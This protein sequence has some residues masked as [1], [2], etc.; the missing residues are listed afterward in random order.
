MERRS[1]AW[2]SGSLVLA[3]GFG[4]FGAHGL[5]ALI[6]AEALAQW[7]TAVEYQF[8]HGLGLLL[9]GG[10][11]ERLPHKAHK[12]IRTLFLLGSALFCGSIYVLST[13]E[14]SGLDG[15]AAWVGPLTPIGGL[16][17]ML[18][19]AVLLITALRGTDPR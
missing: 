6:S 2:A 17:F 11:G 3:V 10:L 18:G 15:A 13:K 4:A 5:R 8:Y 9:A 16:L 19:W 12:A 7:H 14:L 1:I